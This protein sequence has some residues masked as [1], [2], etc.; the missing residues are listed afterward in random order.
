[1]AVEIVIATLNA[2][3]IHASFGLRYL[4]AN[5][6]DLAPRAAMME[7]D[8]NQRPV[9]IVET[10]L[11]RKPRILGLGVYIWNVTPTTEIVAMI[12]RIAP[13][14]IIVLGGPEVS[15]EIEEQPVCQMADYVITDEADFTFTKLCGELFA[16]TKPPAKIIRSP[17]VDV[18]KLPL[19]YHLYS[20]TDIGQR[21][22]YVEA[23]R[24]CPFTCEFCLSSLGAPLRRFPLET[25]L[26]AMQELLD[27]GL[28]HFKFVDR[29]FNLSIEF[30]VRL[31]DFFLAR[32]RPGLFLHFEMIPD[33]LP[34]ELKKILARFPRGSLQ[35]EVGIQT[36]NH[37]VAELIR[38]KQD[39]EKTE[40]N[41]RWLLR[42]TGAHIHA[43]LIVGL[44]GETFDSIAEGFDRLVALGPHEIQF[45]LL[46]RLRGTPITRH[47]AEWQMVYSPHP[48]YEILRNKLLDFPTLQRLRRFGRYWDITANS[49]RF[50]RTAPMLWAAGESAFAN[51][52]KFSDWLFT[53][54]GRA[55]GIA[56]DALAENLLQFLTAELHRDRTAVA[57]A[58]Y[59]DL[60]PASLRET[61]KF[62]R[63][64]A[65]KNPAASATTK[66]AIPKRQAR[67]QA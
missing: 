65:E 3:Y 35:F 23:S 64:F 34:D 9:D 17:P 57:A 10:I 61:P 5:L 48:P 62:L 22:V 66:P 45:N 37:R 21:V 60:A 39:Y 13:E 55:H 41:I 49:G 59:S 50:P 11:A 28:Q 56:L 16:G 67:H 18:A 29:T 31:L 38:R 7:F 32:Y 30:S 47:D 24:G 42:E 46:K 53:K 33:R 51:I 43:D 14:T 19:P 1:M 40:Q 44:P 15:H 58:L 54:F 12:R 2:K 25:I 4:M 6:G 63:D 36:F 27:R 52:M 26:P 20:A 8:I